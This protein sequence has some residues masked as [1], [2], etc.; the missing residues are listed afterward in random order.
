ME[1]SNIKVSVIMPVFNAGEYLSH[2]AHDV[3]GQSLEEIELICIDDGS[4]DDSVQVLKEMQRRDSRVKVITEKNE[5]PSAARNKGLL[6]A[7]GEYV[8]FLDADD[9]FEKDLLKKLYNTAVAQ[10]LDIAV[11]KFDIYNEDKNQFMPAAEET[12]HHIFSPGVVTSKGEHPDH[13]LQS[14]TG[15]VWNKL[16]RLEFLRNKELSFDPELFVFEDV[17]FVSA[18]ISLAE[19]VGRIDDLLIHHRVY[20]EQSRSRLLRKYYS[21]VP[22]VYKKIKEFLMR[23]GMYIPL[24]K[25]YLNLSATR[26]F[27]TCNLL[28]AEGRERFWNTLHADYAEEFGWYRFEKED[29]DS[30]EV[31]EFVVNVGLYTY[32]Q[33]TAREQRGE[34]IEIALMNKEKMNKRLAERHKLEHRKAVLS[35]L[36]VFRKNK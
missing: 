2:A 35:R 7:C 21:Q 23:H 1:N 25:S 30:P 32:S 4:T 14:T 9:F 20:S 15:Y 24:A 6:E 5:G 16:F 31:Y 13:I 11:T 18:A 28:W 3:L 10:S 22:V 19:R 27:K 26:C 34:R 17:Y 36:N 8:I 33:Y 12:P 29:F